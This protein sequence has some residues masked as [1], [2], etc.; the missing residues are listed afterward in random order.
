ML[1]D[2]GPGIDR[3]VNGQIEKYLCTVEEQVQRC[4]TVTESLL[5]FARMPAIEHENFQINELL[6]KTVKL[7]M[8]L[9]DRELKLKMNLDDR[10]PLF[11]G[12]A[13]RLQQVFVNL[14][15]NAIKAIDEKGSIIVATRL[16][17]GGQI[18]IEFRDSGRGIAPEIKDRVFD[19]FF[20][21][22]PPGGGTGLGLSTSHYIIKDMNGKISVESNPG[23]G[24]AFTITLPA[25]NKSKQIIGEIS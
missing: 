8:N 6:T 24:S 5:S 1:E 23:E 4:Q 12:D 2:K 21:T 18:Q 9:A 13:N 17:D 3:A 15:S 19:P 14:L 22:R 7:I 25:D 16:G 20:T 11:H 10:L